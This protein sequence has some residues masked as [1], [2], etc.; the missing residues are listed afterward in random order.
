M[1]KRERDQAYQQKCAELAQVTA[2]RDEHRLALVG[3]T[4][5]LAQVS[6]EI[7][8]KPADFTVDLTVRRRDDAED[9]AVVDEFVD[10]DTLVHR[11]EALLGRRRATR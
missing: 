5:Q 9:G 10:E 8:A 7:D 11:I 2:V 4:D 1:T 6:R 3:L